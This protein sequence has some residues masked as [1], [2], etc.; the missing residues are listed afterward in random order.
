MQAYQIMP[1]EEMFTINEIHLA[2][3]IAEIVSRPG[4]RVNCDV[5]S[6]EIMTEREIKKHG[7]TL[8]RACAG[9]PYYQHPVSIPLIE[10]SNA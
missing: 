7:L 8:C 3:S 10:R 9:A 4:L 1:D 6:E 2:T 5:C